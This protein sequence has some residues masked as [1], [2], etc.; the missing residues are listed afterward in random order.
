MPPFQLSSVIALPV[1]AVNGWK[2]IS[3]W[4]SW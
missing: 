4:A 2:K 3:R 1:S